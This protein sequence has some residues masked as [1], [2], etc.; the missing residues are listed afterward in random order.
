M[1]VAEVADIVGIDVD[2][3]KEN[4]GDLIAGLARSA[5]SDVLTWSWSERK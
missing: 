2:N 4:F 1:D 3:L 5:Q